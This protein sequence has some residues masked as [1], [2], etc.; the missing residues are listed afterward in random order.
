MDLCNGAIKILDSVTFEKFVGKNNAVKACRN[1][2][3]ELEEDTT[4][5]ADAV[6][7]PLDVELA[8]AFAMLLSVY[9]EDKNL[10]KVQVDL[11]VQKRKTV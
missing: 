11:L 8:S 10:C 1:G 5:E 2:D 3:L 4:S 6:V 9:N 7:V